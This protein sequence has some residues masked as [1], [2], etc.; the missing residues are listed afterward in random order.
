VMHT[1]PVDSEEHDYNL[2]WR[3]TSREEL[4]A[5]LTSVRDRIVTVYAM[6]YL[7]D[8]SRLNSLLQQRRDVIEAQWRDQIAA[9]NDAILRARAEQAFRVRDYETAFQC[10]SGILPQRRSR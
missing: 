1:A 3:Y 6:P 5:S 2:R 7:N 8:I 10:Y 4:K 9:H